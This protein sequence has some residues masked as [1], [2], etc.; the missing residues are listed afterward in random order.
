MVRLESISRGDE[1]IFIGGQ[2]FQNLDFLEGK[3]ALFVVS[4]GGHLQEALLLRDT[5]GLSPDSHFITHANPQTLSLLAGTSS[6]FVK[7]VSSRAWGGMLKVVPSILKVNR[8]LKYDIVISTGAAIAISAIPLHLFLR[9]KYFYFESLTRVNRPSMTGKI[10]ELFPSIKKFSPSARNFSSKWSLGPNI[11]DSYSVGVRKELPQKIKIFVTVGTITNYRFDRL[12]DQVLRIVG[13]G[14]EITW[15][16]GCTSR[17]DLPGRVHTTIPKQ[18]LLEIARQSDVVFSHCGIGTL[19]DLLEIGVRPIVLARL[20]K[21]GEHVD[22]HQVQAVK[23]FAK[24]DLVEELGEY[25]TRNTIQGSAR[26]YIYKIN[27]SKL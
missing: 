27:D 18:Q 12:I 17:S 14:D 4:S 7:N 26:K 5:L 20:Q 22:D 21:F 16:I 23:T 24:L 13:P 9:K 25:A 3:V 10:L 19:L 6:F 1:Y 15:Q 2:L 11:L 8:G